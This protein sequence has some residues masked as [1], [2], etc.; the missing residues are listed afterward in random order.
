MPR[1][2]GQ[3]P[4]VQVR[5]S[6]SS[7]RPPRGPRRG[8][9]HRVEE[10]VRGDQRGLHAALGPEQQAVPARPARKVGRQ[11]SL[12]FGVLLIPVT[13]CLFFVPCAT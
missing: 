10:Q 4:V 3:A 7:R 12:R 13:L 9:A 11:P 1:E 2:I 6:L 5:A 8:G